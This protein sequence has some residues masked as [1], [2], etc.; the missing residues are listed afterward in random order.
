MKNKFHRRF[1]RMFMLAKLSA[2]CGRLAVTGQKNLLPHEVYLGF[3]RLGGVYVKFLQL[4]ALRSELFQTL[5]AYDMY[6]VYD[7]VALEHINIRQTLAKELGAQAQKIILENE[8]PFASGSFGQVY[9]AQ[10]GGKRIIVKVLRP[11]VITDLSFDLKILGFF[12]LCI[13]WFSF[14]SAINT[15]RTFKE[16]ARTTLLETNYQLEAD[17]AITLYER[18]KYH[19]TMVIPLTYREVSTRRIICQDY[20]DGIAVTELIKVVQKGTD[21]EKY[22]EGLLGSDLKEQLIT[23]GTE[24]LSS[25]FE[26][27]VAYGD[28][29]PG[30]VKLMSGN[31]VGLIDYGLQAP[32]PR[33]T[34]NFRRL[35]E[36]YYNI[37]S[38]QPD[39]RAYSR[40]LLDM[41]GGDII[42]AAYSLDEYYANGEHLL[43]DS[44]ISTAEEL[45]RSQSAQTNYLLRNN[46]MMLIFT[47]IINRDNRF[48]LKYDLD[49]PEVMR[50]GHL[51]LSLVTNLGLRN[52][53]LRQA[54]GNV[55]ERTKYLD[56]NSGLPS[57]HPET[58]TEILANWFDQISYKNPQLYR[59]IK[60]RQLNYV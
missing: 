30:N 46:K 53:V 54:Y 21:A 59:Q 2:K 18:Y 36:Q 35:V 28:P 4:L 26:Y 14:G 58:A 49:G 41:Y 22:I 15:R 23:L 37:Y 29:H 10:Y 3:R 42:R 51:F 5:R 27:G 12:S 43:L 47:S 16:F 44:I 25:V 7:K 11:S 52:T 38:G 24:I 9:L 19:P 6:D 56:L 8:Q 17:Y 57:L 60:R 39:I 32:A 48:C 50:C 31:R 33:N 20:L 55:L 45:I 1:S 34:L 40:V 13:D